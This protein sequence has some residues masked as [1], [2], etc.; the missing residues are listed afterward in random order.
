[1]PNLIESIN[2]AADSKPSMGD[3]CNHCGWCCMTE[4]CPLGKAEGAGEMIP[5]KFIIADKGKHYCGLAIKSVVAGARIGINEG[6][7]AETQEERLNKLW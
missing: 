7:C 2:L 5:C 4:V 6:C 1:M 3:E